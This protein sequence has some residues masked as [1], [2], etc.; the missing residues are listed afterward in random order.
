MNAFHAKVTAGIA[1][2]WLGL[3]AIGCSVEDGPLRSCM[4]SNVHGSLATGLHIAAAAFAFWMGM[5]LAART[6][7]NWLGWTCGLAS[8]LALAMLLDWLGYPMPRR[9]I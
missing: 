9:D 2:L 6:R 8:F 4:R 5:L 7:R 1:G 3:T